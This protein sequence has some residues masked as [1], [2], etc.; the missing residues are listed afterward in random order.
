MSEALISAPGSLCAEVGQGLPPFPTPLCPLAA[1]GLRFAPDGFLLTKPNTLPHNRV[2]SVA[3]L[4]W[5]SGSSRN[6]VRLPFGISVQLRRNPQEEL[7][8]DQKHSVLARGTI[9]EH[10]IC[11]YGLL[12]KISFHQL[13]YLASGVA[14]PGDVLLSKLGVTLGHLDIRMPKNLC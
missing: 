11:S 6:A 2:A 4:R 14:G 13:P 7:S 8:R 1:S 10:S 12:P 9:R 3:T 5:C